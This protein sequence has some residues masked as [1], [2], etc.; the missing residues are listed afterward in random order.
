MNNLF[1]L[2]QTLSFLSQGF[3]E[4]EG[5]KIPFGCTADQ[6]REITVL[7]PEDI[8]SLE[9]KC[10]GTARLSSDETGGVSSPADRMCSFAV[11]NMDSYA[12]AEQMVHTG[13]GG[14]EPLVLNFA[15]PFQP[16]G[17]VRHGANAQ[18]E[19]LCRKSSLLLSL[20]SDRARAYYQYNI[21]RQSYLSSDA[22][23]LS[24]H[25]EVFRDHENALLDQPFIV[26][27]LT[28]AAPIHDGKPPAMSENEYEALLYQR[29][30]S[31]LVVAACYGHRD[32]VLGAWGCGAFGNDAQM[33]A[34]LF[35]KA[36]AQKMIQGR[37]LGSFFD[38]V[39]FA[40]LDRTR[41]QYNYH[42]FQEYFK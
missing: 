31:M 23:L 32:L 27:V 37:L 35:H 3:Y 28:C 6:H 39:N 30:C 5:E 25:V 29:I 26:A 38:W 14:M 21:R 15:N 8:T 1:I 17:G 34:R 9:Q 42:A 2:H 33:I 22:M 11:E 40:V 20:E 16:G 7:L 41:D 19:D 18:E 13:Q 12:M 10:T 4:R 24:P 36:F